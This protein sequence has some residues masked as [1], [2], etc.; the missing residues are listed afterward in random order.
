VKQHVSKADVFSGLAQGDREAVLDFLSMSS[1]SPENADELLEIFCTSLAL[2]Y[3]FR[4]A[5][6]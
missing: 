5:L 1:R 4:G 3:R 2:K 6:S